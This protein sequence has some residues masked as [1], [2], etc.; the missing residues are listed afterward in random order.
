MAKLRSLFV[1]DD[2][3]SLSEPMY[4]TFKNVVNEDFTDEFSQFNGKALLCWG[5]ADTATPLSFGETIN[6][7]IKDSKL[8]VY[9]GDHYFL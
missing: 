5:E 1:A 6:S 7:L 9:E 4:Q 8:E 2:A 3:K